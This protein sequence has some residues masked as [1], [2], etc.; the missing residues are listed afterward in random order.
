MGDNGVIQVQKE[1]QMLIL[2]SEVNQ[3]NTSFSVWEV[4]EGFR[5]EEGDD[6]KTGNMLKEIAFEHPD[7]SDSPWTPA[8]VKS[9]V[10]LVESYNILLALG[11]G[12]IWGGDDELIPVER[13]ISAMNDSFD[14]E[15]ETLAFIGSKIG[16]TGETRCI[17]IIA[18]RVVDNKKVPVGLLRVVD[19]EY[20]DE[21]HERKYGAGDAE[22]IKAWAEGLGV[23]LSKSGD[24]WIADTEW[25]TLDEAIECIKNETDPDQHA[26]VIQAFVPNE[27]PD[28]DTIEWIPA[29]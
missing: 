9:V 16:S 18:Y 29:E 25:I 26:S 6:F 5:P 3:F 7:E 20:E 12:D 4:P 28:K 19:H 10:A 21:E 17:D 2:V 13:A 23:T 11:G 15:E 24:G 8:Q 14:T 22:R 1:E 27:G